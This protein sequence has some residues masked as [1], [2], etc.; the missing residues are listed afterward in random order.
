VFRAA[1]Q[2]IAAT[3]EG[4]AILAQRRL[5]NLRQARAALLS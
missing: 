3:P 1:V 2:D 4:R 5:G